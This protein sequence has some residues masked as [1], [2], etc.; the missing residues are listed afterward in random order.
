MSDGTAAVSDLEMISD[1]PNFQEWLATQLRRCGWEVHREVKSDRKTVNDGRYRADIIAKNEDVGQEWVGIETKWLNSLKEGRKIGGALNQITN[2]YW[3]TD[4]EG[5][6]V[7]LWA[8]SPYIDAQFATRHAKETQKIIKLTTHHLQQLVREMLCVYGI[9]YLSPTG[10]YGV[11]DFGY[12][13]AHRKI[14]AFD[15]RNP[16]PERHYENVDMEKTA[17]AVLKK[18]KELYTELDVPE[19]VDT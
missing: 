2:Q 11:I 5:R 1:E 19:E 9:G 13:V 7:D 3:H 6:S 14:P 16:V 18:R 4:F 12:S 15:L 8:V 17:N 10:S